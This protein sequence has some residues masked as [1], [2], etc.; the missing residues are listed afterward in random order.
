VVDTGLP[1]G[2]EVRHSNSKNMPYYFNGALKESRWEPPQDTDIEKLKSYLAENH[3]ARE[4]TATTGSANG[5]TNTGKIRA[6]HLLVKHKDSRRPSSW[7]Q[8]ST[9]RR[10]KRGSEF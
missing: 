4:N 7:K 1:D 8:A 3:S 2:W 9:A 6:R 5:N 10:I